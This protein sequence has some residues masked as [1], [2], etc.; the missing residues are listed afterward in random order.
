MTTTAELLRQQAQR[1]LAIADEL[2]GGAGAPPD[3]MLAT[4]PSDRF[5]ESSV[6]EKILN[7]SRSTAYRLGRK[8]NLGWQRPSGAWR[9]SEKACR[10][11]ASG[12][13][14]RDEIEANDDVPVL[15]IGT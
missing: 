11:F 12:R 5:I 3:T 1:L 13:A 7:C 4:V 10:A 2:D 15:Q 8:F 14:S 9:F 6:A